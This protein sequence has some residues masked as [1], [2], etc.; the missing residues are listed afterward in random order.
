MIFST[1]KAVQCQ[2]NLDFSLA[3]PAKEKWHAL[4]AKKQIDDCPYEV[5]SRPYQV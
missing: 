2:S 5:V 3:E 4:R 1:K